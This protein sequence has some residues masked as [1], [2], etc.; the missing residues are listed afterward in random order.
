MASHRE[1]LIRENFEHERDFNYVMFR[2]Y[3]WNLQEIVEKV[4]D[5]GQREKML[6]GFWN[7]DAEKRYPEYRAAVAGLSTSELEN[8]REQWIEK[9]DHLGMLEYRKK[10]AEAARVP[11][12]EN[13][14]GIDR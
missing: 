12:N 8:E 13:E 7:Q 1:N 10:I 14:R 11:A 2:E 4:P 9:L 6:R 3:Q 5:E